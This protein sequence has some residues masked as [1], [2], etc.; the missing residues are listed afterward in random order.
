MSKKV[1]ECPHCGEQRITFNEKMSFLRY[2]TIDNN[3]LYETEDSHPSR[4]EEIWF[5]CIEYSQEEKFEID[6][7][8]WKATPEQAKVIRDMM[9][10][11]H[12][13]DITKH[14]GRKI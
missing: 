14:M 8:E 13:A 2:Y 9:M 11:S 5:R 6:G 10:E 7:R 1:I 4:E 12:S 3:K